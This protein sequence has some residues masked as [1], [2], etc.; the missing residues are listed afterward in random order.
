MRFDNNF[1]FKFLFLKI[2]LIIS[3]LVLFSFH[4]FRTLL[5]SYLNF[6][7]KERL[8][9]TILVLVVKF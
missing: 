8:M 3:T 5:I 2:K 6:K 9:Q 4:I 7:N 1:G